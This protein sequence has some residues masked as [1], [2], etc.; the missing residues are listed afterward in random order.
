MA[1]VCAGVEVQ[2]IIVRPTAATTRHTG[3]G[4]AAATTCAMGATQTLRAMGTVMAT[5]EAQLLRAASVPALTQAPGSTTRKVVVGA[6]NTERPMKEH[7]LNRLHR[8]H[9]EYANA[10]SSLCML[11]GDVERYLAHLGKDEKNKAEYEL[12]NIRCRMRE[13]SKVGEVK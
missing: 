4:H 10:V 7:M 6:A 1:G 5:E 9:I 3:R 12:E 8:T 13:L 11:H 2:M